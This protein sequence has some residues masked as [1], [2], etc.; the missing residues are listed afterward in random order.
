MIRLKKRAAF[1]AV[2]GVLGLGGALY[3]QHEG[4]TGLSRAPD[5]TEAVLRRAGTADDPLP[6]SWVSY[7]RDVA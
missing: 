5:V 4:E 1:V 2:T 6:G 7:G 3:A